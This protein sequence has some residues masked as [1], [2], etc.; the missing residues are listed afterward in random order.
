MWVGL[1]RWDS[2]GVTGLV[3]DGL[4]YGRR[5]NGKVGGAMVR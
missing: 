5:G 4:Q 1:V 3:C 2:G